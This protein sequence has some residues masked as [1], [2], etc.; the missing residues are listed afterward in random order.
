ML[1]QSC[2]KFFQ[3][4]NANT[5][6]RVFKVFISCL[7]RWLNIEIV[8]QPIIPKE[9]RRFQHFEISGINHDQD[10]SD[11]VMGDK[12]AEEMFKED[13]EKQANDNDE[14]SEIDEG[15]YKKGSTY[16]NIKAC[17]CS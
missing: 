15:T 7:I 10:F 11:A 2:D 1:L 6:L 8:V 4:R 3:D 5:F 14:S 12:T 9:Q 16:L 13:M 17:T